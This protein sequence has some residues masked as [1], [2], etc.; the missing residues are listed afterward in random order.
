VSR[1]SHPAGRPMLATAERKLRAI[2]RPLLM[3]K[4]E[5]KLGKWL[6]Q[7][8]LGWDETRR[9]E[10]AIHVGIWRILRIEV[11][12]QSQGCVPLMRPFHPT[13]VRGL[14]RMVRKCRASRL[15][16]HFSKYTRIT[17]CRSSFA[18]SAYALRSF[19]Y[20]VAASTLWTEQ[21]LDRRT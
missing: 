14:W 18:S 1:N 6:E 16:A 10:P 2:R 13:V 8:E 7:D 21:G 20:S 12:K 5:V 15:Q 4:L 19:A 3:R 17:M 11:S 9:D